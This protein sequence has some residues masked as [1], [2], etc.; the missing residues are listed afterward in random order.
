MNVEATMSDQPKQS[1][2]GESDDPNASGG[3]EIKPLGLMELISG[4]FS[5]PADTF[6]RLSKRPQWLG[7]MLLIAVFSTV[8]V[9]VWAANVDAVEFLTAQIEKTNPQLTS[10]Q[11]DMAIGMGVKFFYISYVAVGLIGT[12]FF[13]FF[14]GLLY[15]AVGLMSREDTQWRPTYQ[16]GLVVAAV[17]GLAT[18]PWMILG[19][20]MAFLNP[21]G[22]LRHDQIVPSSLEYWIQSE[23]PKL[24]ALYSSID[25]F[26][27]FQYVLIFIAAKYAMRAKTWGAA[28]CVALTL[29]AV[30]IRVLFAK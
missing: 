6:K 28:L 4:V 29:L 10:Q 27:L 8:F 17:P 20:V 9:I 2:Y 26:L 15:W 12:L 23:N 21:V 13:L 24:S 19:T 22:T 11:L 16:H 3:E 7:A 5:E 30:M 18:V 25:I 1:L 14:F